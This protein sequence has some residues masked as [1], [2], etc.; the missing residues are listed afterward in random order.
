MAHR[1]RYRDRRYRD[2][3]RQHRR[4]YRDGRYKRWHRDWRRSSRYDWHRYR[5][6]NRS[7]FRIGVYYDPF[8][9]RY[10]RFNVGYRL[11]P[12]YYSRSYWISD[13]WRYR[14]PEVWGPYRWVRY[15]DDAL[16]V[17]IYTGQVVDVLYDFFW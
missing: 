12:S 10:R 9:Y 16:L 5:D 3:Y 7:L 2:E 11:W 1:D 15:Y 14:L 13:P 6:R 17:N 8:G 4:D